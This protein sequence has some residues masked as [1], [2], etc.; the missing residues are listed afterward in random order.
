M[1]V[2]LRGRAAQ[3]KLDLWEKMVLPKNSGMILFFTIDSVIQYIAERELDEVYKKYRAKGGYEL[4]I[5]DPSYW[6]D[7]GDGQ[8]PDIRP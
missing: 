7:P 3:K 5:M 8:P 2:F 4:W 1:A 6:K